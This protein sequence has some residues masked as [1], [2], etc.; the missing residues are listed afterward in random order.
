MAK[1]C[2]DCSALIKFA[3]LETGK[4]MPVEALPD[5][6]GNI[7]CRVSGKRLVDAYVITMSRPLQRG[8]VSYMAHWTTCKRGKR[9]P[10][11][12]HPTKPATEAPAPP[13]LF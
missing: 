9:R 11:S 1:H 4:P 13:S 6:K 3:T 2:D 12:I 7:A 10:R 5:D 8:Y